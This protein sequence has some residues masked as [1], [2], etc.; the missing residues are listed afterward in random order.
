MEP[1]DTLEIFGTEGS[2]HVPNLNA[3]ELR[4]VLPGRE[5]LE[6]HPSAANLSSVWLLR[7]LGG[8][9]KKTRIFPIGN[10]GG[11]VERWLRARNIE[12]RANLRQPRN[13]GSDRGPKGQSCLE[14]QRFGTALVA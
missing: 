4:V 11:A 8:Y 12:I 13:L 2:I 7:N 10:G 5:R 9:I 3:G 14:R 1:R 6:A